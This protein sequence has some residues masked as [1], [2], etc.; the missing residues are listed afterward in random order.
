MKKIKWVVDPPPT[1]QYQSF[2]TRGWPTGENHQGQSMFHVQ[3]GVEYE[4]CR[5]REGDHPPLRL[6]VAVPNDDPDKGAWNWRLLKGE[7]KTLGDLKKFAE[8]FYAKNE[9][10]LRR[11]A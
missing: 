9:D 1:G 4:P 11:E 7:F 2:H 6:R 8:E 3:C 10:K 5:V